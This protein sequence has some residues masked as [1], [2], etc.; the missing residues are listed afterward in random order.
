[1]SRRPGR[2]SILDRFAAYF[3]TVDVRIAAGVG[4]AASLITAAL[5]A[6]LA[7]DLG[8]VA[9]AFL[10]LGA[11]LIMVAAA[12]GYRSIRSAVM[13]RQGFYGFNTTAMILLFLAI[14][15]IV[16]FVGERNNTRFDVTASREF[17]LSKQTSKILKELDTEVQAVAFLT[18]TD[19]NQLIVRSRILDL[20]VEY[21]EASGNFSWR[22]VDPDIEPE[23][24][25][26][27][28]INPD[29]EP[30]TVVFISEG[31][32]QQV[33]TL[34]FTPQGRF[35]PNRNLEQ[36]FSQGILSVTHTRQKVV[37]FLTR[38]GERDPSNLSEGTGYGLANEGLKGDNYRVLLLDLAGEGEVPADTAVLIV[39]G[40]E[41]DLLEEE[42][43]PL[44]DYLR[45]GGRALFLL[46]PETPE[47]FRKIIST[48]GVELGEGTIVDLGSAVQTNPRAPLVR[49]SGY[50]FLAPNLFSPITQPIT[51]VSFYERS[52]AISPIDPVPANDL[53]LPNIF[54]SSPTLQVT[55]L[56]V[57]TPLISWLETDPE[58]N[59]I[60]AGELVGPLA[61]GVSIEATAPF[62]ETPAT[63]RVSTLLVVFGDSDFASNRFVSSF[64]NQD[65]FLNSVNWLADDFDLISVRPKLTTPRLLIV[66]QGTWNFIRWSSL[67]ILPIAVAF[68]GGFAWWRRR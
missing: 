63:P 28:G 31:N 32:L 25:R 12:A 1:M 39:A 23:E 14:A 44:E 8:G 36:D 65:M 10:G 2:L 17:S 62:G 46:D 56:A 68:V 55:P 29:T 24:A 52:T 48:W 35:V 38:H 15:S 42:I 40:P 58:E 50:N 41:R 61:I 20:L 64:A 59:R 45:G 57:T 9:W 7:R 5:I 4:G 11:I 34:V 37:R 6:L 33:E 3:S 18:P 60:G 16:I 43:Q 26:R 67:L 47:S 22:V 54:Y 53:D 13:T 19:I 51:D 49:R 21:E 27:L 30:A 66:T